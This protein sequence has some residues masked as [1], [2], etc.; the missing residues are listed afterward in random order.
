MAILR[1]V[2][3]TKKIIDNRKPE[4]GYYEA[5]CEVCGTKFYP[6]RSNAKYCTSNCGLIAH[7]TAVANGTVT[8]KVVS[9]PKKEKDAPKSANEVFRGAKAVYEYLSTVI[10]TNRMKGYIISALKDLSTGETLDIEAYSIKRI[11]AGKFEV[12]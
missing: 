5:E 11:S 8:K 1:Y 9:K 10:D 3:P 7:R 2:P 4:G 12:V 6:E